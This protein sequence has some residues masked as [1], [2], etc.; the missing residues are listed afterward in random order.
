MFAGPT[1]DE[2]SETIAYCETNQLNCEI[3]SICAIEDV[4]ILIKDRH[5]N[6]WNYVNE[7]KITP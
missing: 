3:N 1:N 2:W 5:V 6:N 7:F 4:K